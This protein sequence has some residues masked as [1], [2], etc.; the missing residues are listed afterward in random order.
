MVLGRRWKGHCHGVVLT[1]LPALL[2]C[3]GR[4]GTVETI[5]TTRWVWLGDQVLPRFYEE[6]S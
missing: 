2:W 6:T 4:L 1:K 3:A 5:T